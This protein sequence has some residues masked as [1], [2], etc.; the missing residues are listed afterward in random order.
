M[1]T[2][3]KLPRFWLMLVGALAFGLLLAGCAGGEETAVT[4]PPTEQP[5][6]QTEAHL[7][8][9]DHDD[10]AEILTLPE[11]AA[12]DLQ[13]QPLKVVAT[14]SIIGDVLAQVG[15]EA[16]EL[17]TLMSAGQ[18]PHSYKPAARDLTA[19][20]SANVIF[21]NGW[22][23]EEAL[24]SDL[25]AIG[26]NVPIVPI[27]AN[28]IPLAFGGYGDEEEE[29]HGEEDRH[30]AD[31]HAWFSIHNVGQW[32]KN[33]EQILSALDPINAS[34]YAANASAYQKQLAE[35]EGYVSEQ[36]A[37]IPADRRLLVTNHDAFGFFTRDY[38]FQVLGTVIPSRSTLAEP[39]ARDLAGLIA[40]MGEHGVCTIFTEATVSDK[41]AQTIAAE[42][43]GCDEVKVLKL[44]T[45]AIGPAGSGADSYI[46]MYRA[47]VDAIVAGL[48]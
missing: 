47:N 42:L 18:D 17:T 26:E 40:L 28:I 5:A 31:P 6:A 43:T 12:L 36:L 10:V 9:D 34:Q 24:L 14:T 35:L 33:A 27:S 45:G 30:T 21:V 19:V 4:P 46:G 8:D 48:R 20:A 23:L 7:A 29:E 37:T 2:Q 44:F 11:L 32:V 39:S 22:D 16:I 41:L 1:N 25:E 13:G 38:D 3:Q 15:G